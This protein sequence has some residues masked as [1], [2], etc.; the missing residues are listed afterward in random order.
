VRTHPLLPETTADT[1]TALAG[2][3]G[4]AWVRVS[5]ALVHMPVA[6][7][8]GSGRLTRSADRIA[9]Q[10]TDGRPHAHEILNATARPLYG[11]AVA[12]GLN[13]PRRPHIRAFA[14]GTEARARPHRGM[15]DELG[16]IGAP[17]GSR[18]SIESDRP[19]HGAAIESVRARRG[20]DPDGVRPIL[21]N[22]G[23]TQDST[24]PPRKP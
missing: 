9:E 13:R 5:R 14:R 16:G 23:G 12:S 6:D 8:A 10:R 22:R 18:T 3:S 2:P 7:G 19:G 21:T 15:L 4:S 11:R 17:G 24:Q 1:A 20:T